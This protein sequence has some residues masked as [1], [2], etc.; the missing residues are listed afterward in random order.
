LATALLHELHTAFTIFERFGF[1]PFYD[2][3]RGYDVVY[4]Q[5]V[6]LSWRGAHLVGRAFGIDPSGALSVEME[7]STCRFQAG[8]LSLR[9]AE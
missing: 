3:C 4:S 1:A 2:E 5:K 8:D 6:R 9:P 7:D